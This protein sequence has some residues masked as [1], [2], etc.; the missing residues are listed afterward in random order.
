MERTPGLQWIWTTE[1]W[2]HKPTKIAIY[3]INWLT[4]QILYALWPL[5]KQYQKHV[6]YSIK[7][8]Q[9][10]KE[11]WII[12]WGQVTTALLGAISCSDQRHNPPTNR[13]L[14]C[15]VEQNCY[16]VIEMFCFFKLQTKGWWFTTSTPWRIW[17]RRGTARY[18]FPRK[19]GLNC[20]V[21]RRN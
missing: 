13:W 15:S 21:S 6:Y 2:Q 18:N 3:K 16:Q 14:F 12:F 9:N 7:N 19:R 4:L 10:T 11:F 5:H 17:G 1:L 8:V 20:V